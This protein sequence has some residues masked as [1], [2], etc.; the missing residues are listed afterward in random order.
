MKVLSAIVG[1]FVLGCGS[2]I[3][4]V[5][6]TTMRKECLRYVKA[7]QGGT[8][9]RRGVYTAIEFENDPKTLIRGNCGVFR[10]GK[11]NYIVKE[12]EQV[13]LD[14]SPPHSGDCK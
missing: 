8:N 2:L 14:P 4:A 11:V 7:E 9:G 1:G 5:Q 6:Q 13:E 10:G 12:P 3:V